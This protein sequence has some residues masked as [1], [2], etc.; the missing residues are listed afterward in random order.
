MV[1][2]VTILGATGS[3]GES[4]LD[5]IQKHTDR[6]K[7][8]GLSARTRIQKLAR[9]ALETSTNVVS[10]GIGRSNEF[11]SALNSRQADIRV[12]EGERGLNDLASAEESD[13]V[14]T[15]IV[16]A[17]GLVPTLTAVRAGKT[18]LIANKEPLV[19]M[20]P[21]IMEEAAES[22]AQVI[23]LDS[24]HNAV[25]QCL[26]DKYRTDIR[27]ASTRN[28]TK[29]LREH[30]VEKII[31]TASGGP[32]LNKSA[33][34]LKGVSPREATAHPNWRMGRKISIDSATMMNKGLELIEACA[35][36]SIEPNRVQI[37][38][39]P[40][41]IVHSL[42][43]YVDGSVIAQLASPDMR[44]PIAN[45]LGFPD[46]IYSGSKRLD[47]VRLGVLEFREPDEQQF[48]CLRLARE[49][50][51]TGGTAPTILN[52]ANEVAVEAFCLGKINFTDIPEL[53]DRVLQAIPVKMTRDLESVLGIDTDSRQ[54]AVGL[55][56]R[57]S[58]SA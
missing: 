23:P 10:V 18:V 14:V 4:T 12:L 50:A 13:I 41:S 55:I 53:V 39:H 24:E 3:I 6:F 19:M 22:G 44:I 8:F 11:R 25:F 33:S 21:E 31:L 30:G 17:A 37:V 32:F 28:S 2:Q 57:L 7:V 51:E 47:V 9:I 56:P 46:R 58:G 36:F 45:A 48:P 29:P 52:A 40:Q 20:G 16:G 38:M 35:L 15:G 54:I 5:V 26:P 34:E 43:E 49:A 42:V 1:D 27:N